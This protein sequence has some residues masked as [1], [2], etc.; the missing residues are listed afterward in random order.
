MLPEDRL[1]VALDV[2][3]M[4]S[5]REAVS[6]LRGTVKNF[7]IGGF[8]FTSCGRESVRML[9]GEGM[10]VF[11]DLKLHDIP[12]TVENIS[13]AICAM[14]VKMFDIHA[15]GGSMMMKAAV[16]AAADS[17]VK[18]LV[19]AVTVLT[20]FDECVLIEELGIGRGIGEHV[21]ALASLS[22]E[23][24]VDGIICSPREIAPLRKTYGDKITIVT[25]G[26][27]PAGAAADDQHRVFTPERAVKEGADYIVVGRPVMNAPDRRRAAGEI[28]RACG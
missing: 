4:D 24:G 2:D 5:A 7:K 6:E 26:I 18:T 16:R 3:R 13:R 20:H 1:I 21:M 11:L 17:S 22:V 28:I 12:S 15:S 27:R 19:L 14:D 23:S 9:R 10:D 8:L 25:P